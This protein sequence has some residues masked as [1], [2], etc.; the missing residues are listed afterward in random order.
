MQWHAW[1]TQRAPGHL[2]RHRLPLPLVHSRQQPAQA[3]APIHL[4]L[5]EQ[6][7]RLLHLAQ[8]RADV[9][10]LHRHHHLG[11]TPA[12]LEAIHDLGLPLASGAGRVRQLHGLSC[13][14]SEEVL[15]AGRDASVAQHAPCAGVL[16]PFGPRTLMLPDAIPAARISSALRIFPSLPISP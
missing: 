2:S 15:G 4:H 14:R 3:I 1:C 7:D 10:I 8:Q 11:H 12:L 9:R 5:P 16:S 6:R 13:G